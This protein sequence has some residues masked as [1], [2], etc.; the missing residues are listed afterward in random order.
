MRR[1][2]L[3]ERDVDAGID[4]VRADRG[5]VRAGSEDGDAGCGHE[6]LLEYS[7]TRRCEMSRFIRDLF[8]DI[9][10]FAA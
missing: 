5:A 1:P 7:F 3:D 6:A 2:L 9:L 8:T 10:I 4:E